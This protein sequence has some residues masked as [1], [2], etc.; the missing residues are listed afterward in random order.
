MGRLNISPNPNIFAQ[1][2][3]KCSLGAIIKP[4][5]LIFQTVRIIPRKKK[6]LYNSFFL[7]LV[8]T[9]RPSPRLP[10]ALIITG[11]VSILILPPEGKKLKIPEKY[12]SYNTGKKGK[13]E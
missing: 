5:I 6:V 7:F 8:Y 4:R 13:R 9:N 1:Y 10:I 12:P 11:R 3:A 2:Q